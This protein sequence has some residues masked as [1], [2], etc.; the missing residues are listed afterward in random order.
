MRTIVL[1]VVLA[2]CGVLRGQEIEVLP[3]LGQAIGDG[4]VKV[5]ADLEARIKTL[6]LLTTEYTPSWTWPGHDGPNPFEALRKHLDGQVIHPRRDVSKWTNRELAFT[7]DCDHVEELLSQG[8]GL[9]MLKDQRLRDWVRAKHPARALPKKL[10]WQVKRIV[11]HT[12]A[13]CP[14]CER[15]KA[16]ELPKAQAEGIEVVFAGPDY[17][18]TPAFD[19]TYCNG[20][21]CRVLQFGNVKYQ[22]MK[23]AQL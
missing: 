10:G 5:V 12:Q 11:M 8:K 9:P 20:D 1:C 2:L 16:E 23:N 13:N 14:P 19:V 4:A 22:T 7:H 15:W 17:R 21:Q 6:E 18:G 3:N